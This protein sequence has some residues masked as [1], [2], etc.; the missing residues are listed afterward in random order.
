[1]LILVDSE[2]ENDPIIQLQFNKIEDIEYLE[3]K[4]YELKKQMGEGNG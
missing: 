4:L 3:E 2:I 1:M